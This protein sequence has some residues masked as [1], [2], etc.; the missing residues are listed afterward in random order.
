MQTRIAILALSLLALGLSVTV[1]EAKS[2]YGAI[3]LSPSTRAVGWSY[4]AASRAAAEQAALAQCR[5]HASDCRVGTWFVDA[6]GALAFGSGTKW[7]AAWGT[8]RGG[9]EQNAVRIC[10]GGALSCAVTRWVCVGK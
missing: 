6:C 4:D 3:A 1:A 8:T 5:K 10:G 9:A 7:G 2:K